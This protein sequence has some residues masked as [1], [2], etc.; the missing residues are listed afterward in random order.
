MS[1]YILAFLCGVAYGMIGSFVAEKME[2]PKNKKIEYFWPYFIMMELIE[3][4]KT[5]I[6]N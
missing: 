3:T 1:S 6:E 4:I 5:K 2:K